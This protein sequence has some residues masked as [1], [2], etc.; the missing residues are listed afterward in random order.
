MLF[1]VIYL[2][3]AFDDGDIYVVLGYFEGTG[4]FLN[5]W[6]VVKAKPGVEGSLEK[7]H[8]GGANN[9]SYDEEGPDPDV[10]I[11]Y[12]DETHTLVETDHMSYVAF[13]GEG[14]NENDL[15]CYSDV[16]DKNLLVKDFIDRS[17]YE[18]CSIIQDME[19]LSE[20]AFIIYA[21]AEADS[22]YDV[23]WRMGY[24]RTGWHICAIPF[25][26]EHLDDK[27][28]AKDIISFR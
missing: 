18:N 26:T 21:D 15:F 8:E 24:R 3:A 5:R 25:D 28:L 20:T 22:Q 17:N 7:S 12:F 13:M 14:E 23:G 19:S 4:H 11:V 6:E 2:Q 1:H 10:P 16:Y 9:G 27:G